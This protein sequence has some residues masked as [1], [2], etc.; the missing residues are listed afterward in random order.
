MIGLDPS[1]V[2]G[3]EKF[4][5][6]DPAYWPRRATRSATPIPAASPS[7]KA[8]APCFGRQEGEDCYDLIE[9]LA[10]QDWCTGKVAMSGTSYLTVGQ[11]ITAAE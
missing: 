1:R 6:P 10:V 4:E 2:S 5:G 7:P 9:W 8:T 3:L 11:W